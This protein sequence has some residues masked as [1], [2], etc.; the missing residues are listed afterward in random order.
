MALSTHIQNSNK[1]ISLDTAMSA[2]KCIQ[3]FLCMIMFLLVSSCMTWQTTTDGSLVQVGPEW[4][5]RAITW[6]GGRDSANHASGRGVLTVA[7]SKNYSE[8]KMVVH[9]V[10]GV[11][12][13]YRQPEYSHLNPKILKM[14]RPKGK[15]KEVMDAVNPHE[16]IAGAKELLDDPATYQ[17]MLAMNENLRQENALMEARNSQANR[18]S[19]DDTSGSSVSSGG[20]ANQRIASK[21]ASKGGGNSVVRLP[22]SD[23][24]SSA[25]TSEENKPTQATVRRNMVFVRAYKKNQLD[26]HT[27]VGFCY[28]I[29]SSMLAH[30]LFVK[31]RRVAQAR[32]P[33][34]QLHSAD[35]SPS[36]LRKTGG[37]FTIIKCTYEPYKVEGKNNEVTR[38]AVGYGRSFEESKQN[39]IK[40]MKQLGG[41]SL[42]EHGFELVK[43][44]RF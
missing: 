39:A 18:Y 41:Y 31:T 43:N 22:E 21:S 13:Y 6:E 1:T 12:Q 28:E 19:G 40:R 24:A 20:N 4:K 14:S 37:C 17:T 44:G 30:D 2:I 7:E 42:R 15:L 10:G 11:M 33:G 29:S 3:F 26:N 34:S 25:G 32:Y 16:M 5:N 8:H 35:R 27:D 9:M 38:H 23:S 36:D